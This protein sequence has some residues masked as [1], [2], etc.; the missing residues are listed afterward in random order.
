MLLSI[1]FDEACVD[2]LSSVWLA[3]DLEHHVREKV[4][5]LGR[6]VCPISCTTSLIVLLMHNNVTKKGSKAATKGMTSAPPLSPKYF[7]NLKMV[8]FEL[9][10]GVH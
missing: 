6:G 1:F 7:S 3:V 9:K 2:V 10:Q 8:E 5:L 4:K